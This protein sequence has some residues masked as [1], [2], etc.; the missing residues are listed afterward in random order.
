MCK[1][2]DLFIMCLSNMSVY[3][4]YSGD[5][6]LFRLTLQWKVSHEFHYGW[7]KT[8]SQ[9]QAPQMSRKCLYEELCVFPQQQTLWKNYICC[10]W[11]FLSTLHFHILSVS[12]PPLS[13]LPSPKKMS[14]ATLFIP[15]SE[16]SIREPWIGDWWDRTVVFVQQQYS[17]AHLNFS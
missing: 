1:S 15:L 14:A 11:F 13:T 12:I 9:H 7:T 2:V 4:Q 6:A 17:T 5:Q 8:T 16:K 3:L 10:H